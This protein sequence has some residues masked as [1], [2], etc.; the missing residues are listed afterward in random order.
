MDHEVF[1]SYSS[2]DK[3]IADAVCHTLE[4]YDI[5]CWMAP[6]DVNPG[7]PYAKEIVSAIRFHT[8]GR[9]GMTLLEKILFVADFTSADRNYPDVDAMRRHAEESLD[10]AIL[11]GV[12]YTIRDLVEQSRA[13]H[14][15][16]VALYN[17]IV[18]SEKEA[19]E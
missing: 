10:G 5:P 9:A 17:D 8:T 15:D 14:P 18:L 3:Q 19:N 16:T 6:R 2:S 4:S 7:N 13:V 11:Y 12:A 1:I